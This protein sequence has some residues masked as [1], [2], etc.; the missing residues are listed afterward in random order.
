MLAND[1][2]IFKIG[3]IPIFAEVIDEK[4]KIILVVI[5]DHTAFMKLNQRRCGRTNR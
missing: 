1:A 5:R 3:G 4:Y 2:A